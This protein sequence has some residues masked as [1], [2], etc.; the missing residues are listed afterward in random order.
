MGML[1][2]DMPPEIT[3]FKER[4]FFGLT[5]RQLIC[6]IGGLGLGIPTSIWGGR[7]VSKDMVQWLVLLEAMPFAVIGFFTYNDMP[8]EVIGKKF[9]K[10]YFGKQRRKCEYLPPQTEIQDEIRE[11]DF[12]DSVAI[13]KAEKAAFRALKKTKAYKAERK[14]EKKKRKAR[15]K[16]IRKAGMKR[17]NRNKPKKRREDKDNV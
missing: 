16:A 4:F 2:S 15:L 6:V 13:R 7:F 14:A 17:R 11:I 9:F 3:E 5:V 8:I 10:Y 12:K 1:G